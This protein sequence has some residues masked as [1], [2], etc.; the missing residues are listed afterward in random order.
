V[1]SWLSKHWPVVAFGGAAV[2]IGLVVYEKQKA[3]PVATLPNSG[4]GTAPN[5][6]AAGNVTTVNLQPGMTA[7]APVKNS[8]VQLLL[9]A[10]STW[11]SVTENGNPGGAAPGSAV[12]LTGDAPWSFYATEATVL[13]AL[14]TL[15]G[16]TQ[17]TTVNVVP[18]A[19]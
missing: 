9:P 12:S 6:L 19:S 18:A 17:T 1:T 14:W 2:A 10:G 4:G 16:V 7:I 11:Q 5:G 3:P 8:Q 15:N 13:T